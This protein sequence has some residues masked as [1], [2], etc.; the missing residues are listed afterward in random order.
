MA[1]QEGVIVFHKILHPQQEGGVLWGPNRRG[2]SCGGKEMC[3]S[4]YCLSRGQERGKS[5]GGEQSVGGGEMLM[6]MRTSVRAYSFSHWGA[7]RA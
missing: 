2:G 6:R 4:H 1:F 5:T 7:L 3:T